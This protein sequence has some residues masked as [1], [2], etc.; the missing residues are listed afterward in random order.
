MSR[1]S[2]LDRLY[3]L[4]NR[5]ETN[6]GGKQRLKD[7]TGYMDW[8]DRG[9]YFFFA[10]DE[11]R[12]AADQLRLTRIGTHAVSSGSGTSLWNR[13]RT[14]RGANSGTY[15]DGGNHRG[16]VFRKR[17]GE[18]LIERD[19]LRD[20]YPH[21]GDGSS[22]NRERRLAE[23]EHERRVSEYIRDLPFLWIHVDDEP[24]PQSD[25]SYIERNA[26]ALVSN[27]R[28]DSLDPRSGGWLGRD[29]P[30]SEISD[31]GLWNI[32]HVGEEYDTAFLDRLADAVAD[33]SAL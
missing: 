4:L 24:S 28:K 11:T 14:H 19:G 15:E 23:L 3:D 9:V 30:R 17:V 5:L 12:D 1:H 2:D 20:E 10:E 25:R 13:L 29:S 26:I 22:A 31:S 27:Y 33:T 32:N 7:C 16:S 8:P 18:A 21:W 6:V